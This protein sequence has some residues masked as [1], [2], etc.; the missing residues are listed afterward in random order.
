MPK[1][2]NTS[3]RPPLSPQDKAGF[4]SDTLPSP[5]HLKYR[6]T[7]LRSWHERIQNGKV[8]SD[9][10]KICGYEAA[11][12]ATRVFL[13]FLGVGYSMS[14]TG[15]ILVEKQD[16]H[17]FGGGVIHEIKVQDLDGRFVDIYADLALDERELL[18]HALLAVDK[19]SA[20]LTIGSN[21]GFNWPDIHRVIDVVTRLLDD[22]LYKHLG[23]KRD[24]CFE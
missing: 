13:E 19:G 23:K 9:A 8:P 4:F 12:L 24:S 16:Y 5:C 10:D 22:C 6:M 15:P 3:S 1:M 21:H 17:H 20:H 2:P 7:M 11:S 18:A 14:A